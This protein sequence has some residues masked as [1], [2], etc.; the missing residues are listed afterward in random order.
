MDNRIKTDNRIAPIAVFITLPIL[1]YTLGYFSKRTLLKETISL[2]TI[3]CFFIMRMQ[4][5]LS[6]LN[7]N[8]LKDHKIENP[9]Q[10]QMTYK[11]SWAAYLKYRFQKTRS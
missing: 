8:V 3:I 9:I 1:I 2:L 4:F 7:G 11:P 5:Y 6:R 10:Q